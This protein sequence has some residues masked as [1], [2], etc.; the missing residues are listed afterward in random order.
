MK[1]FGARLMELREK[2]GLTQH[3]AAQLLGVTRAAISHYEKD[4][5]E[6]DFEVLNRLADFFQVT[7][8]YLLGRESD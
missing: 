7:T 3:M 1:G 2:R 6:P 4:R 5:R 8:D